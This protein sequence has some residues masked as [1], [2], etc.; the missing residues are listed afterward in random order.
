M[1]LEILT[2]KIQHKNRKKK[3][4]IQHV[5]IM[6]LKSFFFKYKHITIRNSEYKVFGGDFKLKN[7]S[8]FNMKKIKK[9]TFV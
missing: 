8:T 3:I 1:G 4:D 6:I 7:V 2:P 9:I 5:L